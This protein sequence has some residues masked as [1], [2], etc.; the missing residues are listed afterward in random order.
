MFGTVEKLFETCFEKRQNYTIEANGRVT[1]RY[2][3]ELTSDRLPHVVCLHL[4]AVE[5]TERE[6]LK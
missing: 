6:I 2:N 3:V 5:K 1:L 4:I